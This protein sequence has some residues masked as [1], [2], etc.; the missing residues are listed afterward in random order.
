MLYDSTHP[1]HGYN[2]KVMMKTYACVWVCSTQGL[3]NGRIS[4]C[5]QTCEANQVR[6]YNGNA[7]K[8]I[9]NGRSVLLSQMGVVLEA[10]TVTSVSC[11]SILCCCHIGD[12]PLGDL[13]TFGH[14]P[15]IKLIFLK[16]FLYPGY[17]LDL[18]NAFEKK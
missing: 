13:A 6:N 16:I 15:A 17:L 8:K 14:R 12:H 10:S 11:F 4:C 7:D 18:V 3:L 9:G 2:S 1:P 5:C